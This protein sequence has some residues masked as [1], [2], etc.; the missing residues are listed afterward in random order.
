[1]VYVALTFLLSRG[2]GMPERRLT[3]D[4]LQPIPAE[5]TLVGDAC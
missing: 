3:R 4:H 5:L 1:M 2:F